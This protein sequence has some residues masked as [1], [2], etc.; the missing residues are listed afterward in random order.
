MK[1]GYGTGAWTGTGITSSAA[2]AVAANSGNLHKTAV[3]YGESSTVLGISGTGTATFMGQTV[4]AHSII[5]RYTWVG[6]ANLDGTVTSNDFA[7]LAANYGATGKGWVQGDF[8]FDGTVNAL[9]F[10]ALANNYGEVPPL[11]AALPGMLPDAAMPDAAVNLG[12]VV[13]EPASVISVLLLGGMS[14]GV[15][16]RRD[17]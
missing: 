14:V 9:D 4:D 10:N 11:N 16:R 2:A 6:D 5:A 12:S 13:P 17:R 1:T 8:N 3:G 7:M 15:R